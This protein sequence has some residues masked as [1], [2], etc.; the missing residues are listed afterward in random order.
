MKVFITGSNGFIGK[1]LVKHFDEKNIKVF[2]LVKKGNRCNDFDNYNNVHQVEFDLDNIEEIKDIF[3]EKIDVLYHLAWQGVST[4]YKNDIDKQLSNIKFTLSLIDLA[5][6]SNVKKIILPGSIS[7]YALSSNIVNGYGEPNPADIY[8]AVK[9]ST[10][11]ISDVMCRNSKTMFIS[12]LISSIY[13]PGR[14]DNNLITY[15]IKSMLNNISP[16]YTKLEQKWDYIYIDDLIDTLFLVGIKGKR[17][18]Y[19]VG[20]GDSYVLKDIVYKIQELINPDLELNIGALEYKSSTIDNSI[21]DISSI[22]KDFDFE[23]RFSLNEGI[24]K[25]IDYYKKEMVK[26]DESK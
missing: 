13:G 10:R 24:L 1:K 15:S 3:H 2:A 6:K 4:Q 18:I 22:V 12:V 17:N 14:N 8:G 5:I 23:P 20:S 26:N 9:Y 11:L 7:E 19:T 25:T 21:V 16:S